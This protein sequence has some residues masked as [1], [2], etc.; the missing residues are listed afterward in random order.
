MTINEIKHELD[1]IE[2]ERNKLASE[3]RALKIMLYRMIATHGNQFDPDKCSPEQAEEATG[4]QFYL[5]SAE[6]IEVVTIN[7]TSN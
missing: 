1:Q 6:T 2:L 7:K 3:N 4:K 5:S